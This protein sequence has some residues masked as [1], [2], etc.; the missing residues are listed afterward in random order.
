MTSTTRKRAIALAAVVL[1]VAVG[2]CGVY[3]ASSGRIDENLRRVAV[4]YL[5]NRTPEPGIEIELTNLIISAL[6]DDRTMKVVGRQEADTELT[7]AVLH[8]KLQEAFTDPELLV[9]EYQ[10]QILV[11]LTLTEISTGEPVF[12]R[13]RIRGTGNFI[14]DDPEGTSEETARAEAADEIIRDVLAS[15][16]E[17]W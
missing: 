8:Y 12:T 11:E 16:V 17:D 2:G 5:E 14:V 3:S 15:V 1:A 10:V 9:D 7:G 6:Q 13:K 4:P